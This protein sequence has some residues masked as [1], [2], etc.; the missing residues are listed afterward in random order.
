MSPTLPGRFHLCGISYAQLIRKHN[1][2]RK[3]RYIVYLKFFMS[4]SKVLKFG[5]TP[6]QGLNLSAP[7]ISRFGHVEVRP[8]LQSDCN[9]PGL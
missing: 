3:V 5:D 1:L 7:E 6:V 4:G 2:S 8:G 9:R